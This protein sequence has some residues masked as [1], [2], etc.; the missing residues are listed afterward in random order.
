MSSALINQKTG[1]IRQL[2]KPAQPEEVIKQGDVEEP[3]LLTRLLKRI[4][5]DVAQ[6]KRAFA[7]R[8]ITFTDVASTGSSTVPSRVTLVH[9]LG[10][11]VHWYVVRI[12]T[13]SSV[14]LPLYNE[15]V[16]DGEKLT[17]DIYYTGTFA[18]RVEEK[19]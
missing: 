5:G 14:L 13:T 10:G 15:I 11:V 7:P 8:S 18:I 2:D 19:G 4:L 6:L 12:Q 9:G 16:N 1:A 3:S 17:L